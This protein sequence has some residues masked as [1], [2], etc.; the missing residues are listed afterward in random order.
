MIP[1]GARQKL[2]AG[3]D[4]KQV[5]VPETA[6]IKH[7]K[8][9]RHLPQQEEIE[10]NLAVVVSRNPHVVCPKPHWLSPPS[11]RAP[12]VRQVYERPG[13]NWRRLI[14][15]GGRPSCCLKA[16]AKLEEFEKPQDRAISA[17]F[18]VEWVSKSE[19]RRSLKMR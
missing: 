13:L 11:P 4:N 18:R 17:I 9:H 19:A 14:W 7:Y 16:R 6:G 3:L 2:G 1:A 8:T 15:L 5:R 12:F 10:R